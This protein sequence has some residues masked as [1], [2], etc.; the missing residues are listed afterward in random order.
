LWHGRHIFTTAESVIK[1]TTYLATKSAGFFKDMVMIVIFYFFANLYGK[2]ILN[3]FKKSMPITK[4]EANKL[5][6]EVS[7]V[8][9][10]VFYSI[11]LTAMFEGFLFAV[12]GVSFGYDA[13]F[14]GVMY[15]FASLIPI[16][17]GALMWIPLAI[18]EYSQGHIISA[19]VIVLYSI[20]II[21]IIA[22]TFIKPII[23]K[24]IGTKLTKSQANMNELLVFFSILAGLSSF[25]FWGMILGPAITTFF[26]SI[27][28]LYQLKR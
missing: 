12:L 22:D 14:L 19:V 7:N 20:V 23:I 4:G 9:G 11:L 8:M 1:I 15:G 28:K 25:G 5:S 26:I 3:F 6:S 27:I 10:V 21:S 18:L 16:V 2:D 13:L 17:G 24:F